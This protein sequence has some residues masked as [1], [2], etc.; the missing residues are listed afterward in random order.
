MLNGLVAAMII[1]LFHNSFLKLNEHAFV[2]TV[3][4]QYICIIKFSNPF[5]KINKYNY[6]I[7]ITGSSLCT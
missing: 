7:Y 6:G 3:Y 5:S 4:P 2:G 1:A